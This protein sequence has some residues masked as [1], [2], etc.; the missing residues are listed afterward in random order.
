MRGFRSHPTLIKGRAVNSSILRRSSLGDEWTVCEALSAEQTDRELLDSNV[1][2]S[3]G[4][5]GGC[6][7]RHNAVTE[8]FQLDSG[9]ENGCDELSLMLKCT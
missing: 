1:L 5:N 9:K 4:S 8:G 7:Q 3:F 2:L 6:W